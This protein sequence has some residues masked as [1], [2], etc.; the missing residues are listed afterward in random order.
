[1]R[2]FQPADTEPDVPNSKHGQRDIGTS[3]EDEW[4]TAVTART[5][6]R[7]DPVVGCQA[8]R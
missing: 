4:S 5:S 3:G 2:S 7:S 8:P 6:A 1:M